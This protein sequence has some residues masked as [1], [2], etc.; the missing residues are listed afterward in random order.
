MRRGNADAFFALL[1]AI[2]IGIAM[3]AG[4]TTLVDDACRALRAMTAAEAAADAGAIGQT[5][6]L[7][8]MP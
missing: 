1:S 4:P 5:I 3:A 8:E 6:D 7:A 2:A